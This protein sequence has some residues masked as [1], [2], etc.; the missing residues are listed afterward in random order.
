MPTKGWHF[1]RTYLFGWHF[2][3]P[4]FFGWHF[5]RTISTSILKIRPPPLC[6]LNGRFWRLKKEIEV[7][8][9]GGGGGEVIWTK[10]KRT[11]T[12]FL[13]TIPYSKVVKNDKPGAGLKT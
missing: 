7:V 8:Q 2:A 4:K 9:T 13:E 1:V 12:F 6:R 11:A 5:V 3:R 10:S